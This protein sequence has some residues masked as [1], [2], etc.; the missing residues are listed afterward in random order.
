MRKLMRSGSI[1]VERR[2][3]VTDFGPQRHLEVRWACECAYQLCTGAQLNLMSP[4][5]VATDG[6]EEGPPIQFPDEYG[7]P[8][9]P[10]SPRPARSRRA[11]TTPPGSPPARRARRTPPGSSPRAAPTPAAAPPAVPVSR[12][13]MAQRP[14]TPTTTGACGLRIYF[15]N[16]PKYAY[17]QA[18]KEANE[19]AEHFHWPKLE[20]K[21]RLSQ[22]KRSVLDWAHGNGKCADFDR[23]DPIAQVRLVDE[24]ERDVGLRPRG[25]PRR[26][27]NN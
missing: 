23:L 4:R 16:Q 6:V 1:T 5:L 9:P 22:I 12:T 14:R 18:Q 21:S 2:G 26:A 15:Q 27:E 19:K 8:P 7:R 24:W 3:M 11:P 25:R 17:S 13:P 10:R 20:G